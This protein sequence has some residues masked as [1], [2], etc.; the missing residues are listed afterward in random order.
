M[1]KIAGVAVALSVLSAGPADA[2]PRDTRFNNSLLVVSQLLG[3]MDARL[4]L[5]LQGAYGTGGASY[6]LMIWPFLWPSLYAAPGEPGVAYASFPGPG[7]EAGRDRWGFGLHGATTYARFD[8]ASPALRHRG[9]TVAA[10]G[11][12]V[13]FATDRVALGLSAFHDTTDIETPFNGGRIDLRGFTVSPYA[14]FRLGDG[15][16]LD[17]AAGIGGLSAD[18]TR[19]DGVQTVGGETDGQRRFVSI[20]IGYA[21]RIGDLGFG[22]RAGY[23]H[24]S[25]AFDAFTET[26]GQAAPAIDESL[27]VFS[28]GGDVSYTIGALTPFVGASVNLQ[29]GQDRIDVAPYQTAPAPDRTDL[30]LRAGL[31]LSYAERVSASVEVEHL[32][33]NDVI[34][35]TSVLARASVAF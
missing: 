25:L 1:R 20:G 12:G 11:G 5:A 32:L 35:R 21:D 22:V 30:E 29:T 9:E 4:M 31:A 33:A 8:V 6:L 24:Q 17:V 28:L 7:S 2:H 10:G 26:N 3:V 34:D 18:T 14:V 13:F 19:H 16:A 15:L 27:G 23:M